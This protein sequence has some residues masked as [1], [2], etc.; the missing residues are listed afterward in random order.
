[1]QK[2][3]VFRCAICGD[4]YIGF[5]KPTNCPFCGAHE[6]YMIPS[7]EWRDNN[8]V[9]LT[10]VSRKNLQSALEIE[11]GN[12]EFYLCI[13]RTARSEKTRAMFK[14]L[15]KVESEHASTICKILRTGKPE[16][17]FRKETC[18]MDEEE[19]F[20]EA[21]RRENRAVRL[22]TEFLSQ[23]TEPRV[24]QF[25][26]AL[27]EIESDHIDLVSRE[28]SE[29]APLSKESSDNPPEDYELKKLDRDN[30]EF[31]ESYQLHED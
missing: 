22:Y 16:I 6:Q 20:S 7:V 1:M 29:P 27:I 12:A 21:D 26:T 31:Y 24:R 17:V 25:F 23:A 2:V 5:E 10:E 18:R 9:D 19:L 8:K 11:T 3:Q 14:A 28:V 13:S 15:S 4:P 30:T